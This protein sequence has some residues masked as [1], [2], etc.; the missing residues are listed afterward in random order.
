MSSCFE[1]WGDTF[2]AGFITTVEL[3][4]GACLVEDPGSLPVEVAVLMVHV[5]L[6][7]RMGIL[8]PVQ[9]LADYK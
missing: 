4:W 6:P 9:V 2:M 7:E 8:G 1:V 5:V 3:W